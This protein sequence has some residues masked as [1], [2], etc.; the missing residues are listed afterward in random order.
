MGSDRAFRFMLPPEESESCG[1]F[2]L[3]VSTEFLDLGWI[4]QKTSPF[5]PLFKQTSM[6]EDPFGH[7]ARWDAL[8]VAL[9]MTRK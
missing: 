5:D 2:K 9:T 4:Q 7:V 1:F 6:P 3:F 8:N